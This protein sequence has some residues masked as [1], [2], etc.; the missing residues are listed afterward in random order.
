MRIA[1]QGDAGSFHHLAANKWFGDDIDIVACETFADVFASLDGGSADHAV[2]AIKN[3][4]YGVL[5]EVTDLLKQYKYPVIGELDEP[6]HQNLISLP[7]VA[8]DNIKAVLSHPVAL[9]QCSKF[10]SEHLPGAER[11]EYFDTAAAV[12]YIKR[13]ADSSMAAIAGSWAA[14]LHGLPILCEKI[15]NELDNTTTFA[16]I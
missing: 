10:L 15:E 3:S 6:V 16:I 7:A 2:V 4:W 12:E 11:R 8:L 1:I 13:Q 14:E 9:E 5:P